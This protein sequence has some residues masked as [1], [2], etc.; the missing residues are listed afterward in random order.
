[1]SSAKFKIGDLVYR[2]LTRDYLLI[3]NK[4]AYENNTFKFECLN[5]TRQKHV[6]TFLPVGLYKKV[7]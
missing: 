7:A 5:L 4:I 3:T 6:V 2:K 1:M